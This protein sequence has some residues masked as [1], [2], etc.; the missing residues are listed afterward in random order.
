MYTKL[1]IFL[2]F[3]TTMKYAYKL[4]NAHQILAKI[5]KITKIPRK[6]SGEIRIKELELFASCVNSESRYE[7]MEAIGLL[8]KCNYDIY[9]LTFLLFIII[10]TDFS[11]SI[12][13][14][15]RYIHIIN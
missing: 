3:I 6:A 7:L 11:L 9:L 10:A 13:P 14:I 12:S 2:A 8:K 4:I 1:A 5:D 15:L